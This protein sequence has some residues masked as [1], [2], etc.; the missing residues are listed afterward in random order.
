MALVRPSATMCHGLLC[1]WCNTASV[2]ASDG[3]QIFCPCGVD[4]VQGR[5][6]RIRGDL[7][8]CCL[9]ACLHCMFSGS[10]LCL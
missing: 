9:L 8:F 3:P 10:A 6:L 4:A 1:G 2:V 5:G 7:R